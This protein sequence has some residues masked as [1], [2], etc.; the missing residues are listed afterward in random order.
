MLRRS[1][2]RPGIGL[3]KLFCSSEALFANAH[4][5]PAEARGL[6]IRSTKTGGY[7]GTNLAMYESHVR[8]IMSPGPGGPGGGRL[9]VA[10]ENECELKDTLSIL[11]RYSRNNVLVV[12]LENKIWQV[13]PLYVGVE[14]KVCITQRH[15]ASFSELCQLQRAQDQLLAYSSLPARKYLCRQQSEFGWV[16]HAVELNLRISCKDC[17]PQ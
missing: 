13:L 16:I 4:L 9:F 14:G 10:F 6:H 7:S 17:V 12:M 8:G 1:Q 11:N 5:L 15:E 2:H 3:R